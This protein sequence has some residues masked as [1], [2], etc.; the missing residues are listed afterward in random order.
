[1]S[2]ETP[3]LSKEEL[4]IIEDAVMKSAR[5]IERTGSS[6]RSP[7]LRKRNTT[8]VPAGPRPNSLR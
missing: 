6:F 8:S 7:P 3:R 4:K 1:M 2:N 5:S